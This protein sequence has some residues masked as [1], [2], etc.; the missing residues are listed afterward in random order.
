MLQG[1]RSQ[2]RFL[3]KSLD[4]FLNLPNPSSRTMALGLTQPLTEMSTGSLPGRGLKSGR[5]V[6]LTTLPPSV[7]RLSRKCGILAVSQPYG[8]LRAVTGL[9]FY[10]FSLGGGGSG[11]EPRMMMDDDECGAISG[12]IGKGD[13]STRRKPTPLPL[14]AP[15]I[16]HDLTLARTRAAA[17]G[18]WLITA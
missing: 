18:S 17:V 8:P 7:S 16:P 12:T 6:K 14:C 4:L 1:G 10:F 15:Q 5:N 9:Y 2:I 3:M 11:T 13:Q